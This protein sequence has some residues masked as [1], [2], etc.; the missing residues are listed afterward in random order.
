MNNLSRIVEEFGNLDKYNACPEFWKSLP[1]NSME[2]IESLNSAT[3]KTIGQ[4]VGK[5]AIIALEYGAREELDA[6]ANNLQSS[7]A[8]KITNP[9]PTAIFPEEFYG[10]QRRAKP[11]L[12]LQGALHGGELT[13]T[14]ASLNLCNIIETGADLR[15]KAWPELQAMA[16]QY[17]I[18]II[19]WLNPD[20]TDRAGI[21]CPAG[22]PLELY[23]RLTMGVNKDGSPCK[24]P[25]NKKQ[26]PVPLDNI[27]YLGSYYNDH[28][29]NLQYD[30][31]EIDRQPETKAWM[32]YY[33]AEKPDA[34]VAWHCDSGSM[35]S[36]PPALLPVGFQHQVSRIGGAVKQSLSRK[37]YDITRLSWAQLPGTGKDNLTQVEA[38]YHVCGA[39]PLL[40]ELPAG[41]SNQPFTPDEMLDI[42]L[43]TLEELL[44]FEL[45]DG[46]RPYEYRQK[47]IKS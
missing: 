43:I 8:A 34:V 25:E 44:F 41:T 45:E 14:V 10:S 21:P 23:S 3:V 27:A 2:F 31:C 42:S 29:Y 12:V 16:K 26:Y 47:I 40:C 37:G 15:G 38:I 20:G 35:I 9:D 13:G 24:Y 1:E 46:F 28:G 33:L 32:K 19:P 5:R 30:F 18:L 11:V 36:S 4:S 22:M 39:L 17:R 7:M 6:T